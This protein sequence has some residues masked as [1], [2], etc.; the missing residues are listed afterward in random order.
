[1]GA[2]RAEVLAPGRAEGVAL[3]EKAGKGP[4]IL[5]LESF[6]PR[7]ALMALRAKGIIVERGGKLSHGAIYARELGI[8]CVRLERAR[9]IIKEGTWV[10]IDGEIVELP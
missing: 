2:Y 7:H 9:E 3:H 5:V 8:P 10:R 6:S 1:M 4:Y